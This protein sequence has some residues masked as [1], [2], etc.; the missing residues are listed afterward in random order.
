MPYYRRIFRSQRLV[1]YRLGYLSTAKLGDNALGSIR[2]SVCPFVRLCP[3]SRPNLMLNECT[4]AH[5]ERAIGVITSLRCLSV[6]L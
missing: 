5:W 4:C 3:L 2:L 1:A 6:C